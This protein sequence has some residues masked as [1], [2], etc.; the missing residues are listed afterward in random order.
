M[1]ASP[2]QASRTRAPHSGPF[3]PPPGRGYSIENGPQA[4][5]LSTSPARAIH[6]IFIPSPF[7]IRS[8]PA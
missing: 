4:A 6:R 2:A 3:A 7:D 5:T 1:R 8:G